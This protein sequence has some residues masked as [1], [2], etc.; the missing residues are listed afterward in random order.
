MFRVNLDDLDNI[1]LFPWESDPLFGR[2]RTILSGKWRKNRE[3]HPSRS[4]PFN[5]LPL[6]VAVKPMRKFTHAG[7]SCLSFG[8]S[9][10]TYEKCLNKRI[11]TFDFGFFFTSSPLSLASFCSWTI[12]IMLLPEIAS[13]A[14]VMTLPNSI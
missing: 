11:I 5:L 3:C 12:S 8:H 13:A 7:H 9:A 2:S 10:M 14:M 6:L 1:R 4:F